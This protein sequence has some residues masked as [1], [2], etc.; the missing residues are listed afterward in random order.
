MGTS[1]SGEPSSRASENSSPPGV[2]TP[3]IDVPSNAVDA[4]LHAWQDTPTMRLQTGFIVVAS[5]AW[6]T[7]DF[8][9]SPTSV[10]PWLS[11]NR[12]ADEPKSRSSCPQAGSSSG[13]G[14][15]GLSDAAHTGV[16]LSVLSVSVYWSTLPGE[17]ATI[18]P[19]VARER[20]RSIF[21]IASALGC[22]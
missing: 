19:K 12:L 11:V 21:R 6:Y 20:V 15:V 4:A 9:R 7:P 3:S 5:A 22:C 8:C 17:A 14:T 10:V 16:P 13:Y 2:P 18:C 1:Q